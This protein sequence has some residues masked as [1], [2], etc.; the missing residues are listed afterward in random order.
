MDVILLSSPRD[1]NQVFGQSNKLTNKI[2]REFVSNTFGVPETFKRFFAADDTGL[3]R[4]PRPGSK[5][6]AEHR[7]DYLMH[8]LITR[9][10]SGP[11]LKPLATRF[12]DNLTKRLEQVDITQEWSELPDLYA[13][14]QEHVFRA[15]VEAMFGSFIFEVNPEFC[16]DF[17]KFEGSVPELAKGLPRFLDHG[18][19]DA[20]DKCIA[21]IARWQS[22]LDERRK[23]AGLKEDEDYD[24][25]FGSRIL[26]ERHDAF[27][28]MEPMN[29]K[30]RASE[31]LALIWGLVYP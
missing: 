28:K 23:G 29:A 13:F 14:L 12:S 30:A 4:E 17:W 31:D 8:S 2:Y 19:Y 25:T 7:V 21:S 16:N 9:F 22:L 20:R 11:S 3:S 26:Q 27:A 6:K 15:S 24:P 5:V 1:I 18:A 10:L